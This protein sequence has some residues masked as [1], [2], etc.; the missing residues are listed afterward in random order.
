MLYKCLQNVLIC[1][2]AVVRCTM[3]YVARIISLPP[4]LSLL[5]K[6]LSTYMLFLSLF[7]AAGR[8]SLSSERQAVRDT[9]LPG[10]EVRKD[11]LAE[12]S[13]DC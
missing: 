7:L 10:E 5:L 6:L 2:H 4:Q 9:E 12:S 3:C 8:A 11:R 13:Q 1:W